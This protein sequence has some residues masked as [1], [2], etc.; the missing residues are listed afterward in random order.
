MNFAVNHMAYFL[1]THLL[2]DVL[3]ASSPAR[4][5]NVT[6]GMHQGRRLDF[7]DLQL[8]KSYSSANAYACS[9]LMNILFTYA[10]DRRLAGSGVTINAV[11]PGFTRTN[12]GRRGNGLVG[13]L[14]MPLAYLMGHSAEKGAE[15]SI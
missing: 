13:K 4:I 10:L 3:K 11:H 12:L 15:T 9:K 6:S 1:L 14:V 8:E 7:D 2:L 5:I